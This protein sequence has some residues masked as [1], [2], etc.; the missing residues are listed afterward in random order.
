MSRSSKPRTSCRLAHVGPRLS[1][2]R[3][4]EG[5]APWLSRV[6]SLELRSSQRKAPSVRREQ[7]SL[8][9]DVGSSDLGPGHRDSLIS[10]RAAATR[11][12]SWCPDSPHRVPRHLLTGAADGSSHGVV[13][14]AIGGGKGW[15]RLHPSRGGRPEPP[16]SSATRSRRSAPVAVRDPSRGSSRS[17]GAP[18]RAGRKVGTVVGDDVVVRRARRRITACE[19]S[20]RAGPGI[21][22]MVASEPWSPSVM[23]RWISC[24]GRLG[25]GT[26]PLG[27]GP[28]GSAPRGSSIVGGRSRPRRRSG[29]KAIQL[30]PTE[31]KRHIPTRASGRASG[32]AE[33]PARAVRRRGRKNPRRPPCPHHDRSIHSRSC[34]ETLLTESAR[35]KQGLLQVPESLVVC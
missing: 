16:G 22:A 13:V 33:R 28:P 30:A 9:G 31:A 26:G 27:G 1:A 32:E 35:P 7:P 23:S 11:V 8:R 17:T 6:E 12:T 5:P 24:D 29:W 25:A 2:E 3:L 20:G 10:T 18:A 21:G 14:S 4:A 19:K 15:R 34:P